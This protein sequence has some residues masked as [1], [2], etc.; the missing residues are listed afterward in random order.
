MFKFLPLVLLLVSC[1]TSTEQKQ[2]KGDLLLRQVESTLQY[3]EQVL[4]HI[5]SVAIVTHN[6]NV[7]IDDLQ[8]LM[9]ITNKSYDYKIK[10][11]NLQVDSLKKVL[12]TCKMYIV[13]TAIIDYD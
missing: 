6:K 1:N 3:A 9:S 4:P 7:I 12:K 8:T 10:Q 5:D 13:D 2:S 11:L